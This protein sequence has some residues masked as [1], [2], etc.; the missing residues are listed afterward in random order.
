M[1]NRKWYQMSQNIH[2]YQE[3]GPAADMEKG[4]DARTL[5]AEIF[6][7]CGNFLIVEDYAPIFSEKNLFLVEMVDKTFNVWYIYSL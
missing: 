3:E 6:E 4:A 2:T 5:S 7:N 1:D